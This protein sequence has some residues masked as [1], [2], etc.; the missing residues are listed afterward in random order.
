MNLRTIRRFYD[1]KKVDENGRIGN[2]IR[3]NRKRFTLS[4]DELAEMTGVQRQTVSKWET[5]KKVPT[6][7]EAL[8]LCDVFHIGLDEL[9]DGTLAAETRTQTVLSEK[10][11]I[12]RNSFHQNAK[13]VILCIISLILCPY[14]VFIMVFPWYLSI[15]NKVSFYV[16]V[17]KET[18][19]Y[20]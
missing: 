17:N 19:S 11:K 12:E 6:L 10:E 4:Q 3:E 16:M 7:D 13:I 2:H 15:K 20:I 5:G 14:G 18:V 1:T 8:K 9:I